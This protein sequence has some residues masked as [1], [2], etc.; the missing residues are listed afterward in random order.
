MAEPREPKPMV[1]YFPLRSLP[2]G[3]VGKLESL[4]R[5]LYI[6]RRELAE[7]DHPGVRWV[8]HCLDML[9]EAFPDPAQPKERP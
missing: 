1:P 2:A 9:E 5:S 3:S 7:T 8:D 4:N 6:L